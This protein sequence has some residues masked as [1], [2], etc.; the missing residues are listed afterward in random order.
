MRGYARAILLL[1]ILYKKT[2]R[3]MD[4]DC[5]IHNRLPKL[6]GLGEEA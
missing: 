1:A 6:F 2:R 4:E 3:Y 5:V